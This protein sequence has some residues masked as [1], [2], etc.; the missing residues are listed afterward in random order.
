MIG[1][2]SNIGLC[3]LCALAVSAFAAQG[4]SA[5]FSGTT[6]S[7]CKIVP[8]PGTATTVGYSDAHCKNAVEN[9]DQHLEK[10]KYEHVGWA[11]TGNTE[12]QGSNEK[13][14][15]EGNENTVLKATIAGFATTL[16]ATGVEGTNSPT[17]MNNLSG[18]EHQATGEG[19][20]KYTG[21]TVTNPA[22]CSVA[23]GTVTTFQLKATTAGQGM[24]LKFEPAEGTTFAEFEITGATCPEGVK[25]VKKVVGSVVSSSIEGATT[26]FDHENTTG[27]GTLRIGSAVGPKAGIS[28]LLTLKTRANSSEEYLP[29]AATTTAP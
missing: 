8:Q 15:G 6:G 10:V 23:G 13:T 2:R 1:R 18:E 4:A 22:G 11:G 21:V 20:I 12:L 3:M 5:A 9:D 19:K 17:M 28:G 16:Q 7:Q 14:P 29:L 27:Q 26:K 24:A 25:G